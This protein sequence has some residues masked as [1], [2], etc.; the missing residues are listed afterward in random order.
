MWLSE[1]CIYN[2]IVCALLLVRW[3]ARLS[4]VCGVAWLG[5]GLG[6][7]FLF[8]NVPP[9][10]MLSGTNPLCMRIGFLVCGLLSSFVILS[11]VEF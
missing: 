8:L 10:I 3:L 1:M 5:I 6:V 2:F 11:S 4:I 7:W 9:W